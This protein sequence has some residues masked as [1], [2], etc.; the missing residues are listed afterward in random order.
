MPPAFTIDTLLH[1]IHHTLLN[2]TL[3]IL[4]PLTLAARSPTLHTTPIHATAAFFVF[5]LLLRLYFLLDAYVLAPGAT[6]RP[7]HWSDEVVLITGGAGGLGG[8]LAEL[9]GMRGVR[10]AVADVLDESDARVRNWERRG[11][12]YYACDVG[13]RAAVEA[14]RGRVEAELG[15]V[16]VLVNNA[17]VVRGGGLGGDGVEVV[18]RTNVM[19]AV[20]TMQV[21]VPGMGERE[22]GGTVVNVSSVL[23]ELGAAGL[24]A[25]TASK[26][27][28]TALHRS[29]AAEM[30]MKGGKVRMVLVRPGQLSTR[31]FAEVKPPSEFFGP[32][33]EV[34][35]LAREMVRVIDS[36]RSGE[37][38][39]PIYAR[40]IHWMFVLPVGLRDGVV[41][42]LAGLDRGAWETFGR[43]REAGRTSEA[44]S[45]I[46]DHE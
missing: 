25:Y 40:W 22:A 43:T 17:A 15:V 39:I 32:V 38:S 20:W 29:V 3:T 1:A 9:Y 2:P 13:E 14:L 33:V 46:K 16:S 41:R 42:K 10:V 6:P 31:M 21:F 36:G 35:E 34:S 23:G 8:L 44:G 28:L 37:V 12:R 19:A 30:E 24:G 27:A 7:L 5:T 11:V 18:L 26:G 45:G 4:A